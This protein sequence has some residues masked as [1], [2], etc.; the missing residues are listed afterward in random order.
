MLARSRAQS[1][2]LTP[3]SLCPAAQA[4]RFAEGR[5]YQA[6]L[7]NCI[8]FADFAV[9]VLTGGAVRS[10][11]LLF[12]ALVGRVSGACW[13]LARSGLACHRT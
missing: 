5:P 7:N 4:L 2:P 11:P 6:L 13:A 1:T 10:A 3:S 9:R 8:A 12:D